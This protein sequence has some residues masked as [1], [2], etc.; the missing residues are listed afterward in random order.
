MGLNRTDLLFKLGNNLFKFTKYIVNKFEKDNTL[1][2]GDDVKK[3]SKEEKVL[4]ELFSIISIN[5]IN[6]LFNNISELDKFELGDTVLRI[7][8]DK[9]E[10]VTSE[11]N[12]INNNRDVII[13]M[14][15]DYLKKL[16]ISVINVT[17][18]PMLF[19][20]NA[21]YDDGK[22]FPYLNS[23]ISHIYNPFDTILKKKH[24]LNIHTEN[25]KTLISSVTYINNIAFTINN[26][27]LNFILEEW[28]N[29]NSC[30][31]NGQNKLLTTTNK[32]T[33]EDLKNE[34]ISQQ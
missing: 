11:L 22:Y 1:R 16:K 3:K 26:D 4:L 10:I 32:D 21:P 6:E 13:K 34:T 14:D 7:I 2:K 24:D 27:M 19:I 23:E 33:K 5:K 29:D 15:T 8:L 31:F 28:E 25:Q 30:Y 12:T 17:Q 9:T 18:L 20:P